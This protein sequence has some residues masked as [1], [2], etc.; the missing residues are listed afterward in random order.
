MLKVVYSVLFSNKH[1]T[2]GFF[3]SNFCC[4][5]FAISLPF[6][7]WEN[8]DQRE[9]ASFCFSHLSG[10]YIPLITLSWQMMQILSLLYLCVSSDALCHCAK[11]HMKSI[12]ARRMAIK[13]QFLESMESKLL[14]CP[15]SLGFVACF[16]K[17]NFLSNNFRLRNYS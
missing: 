7:S 11:L 17:R 9:F 14:C 12:N 10:N 1:L 15:D 3:F 5:S 6:L 2:L 16:H 8:F 4:F 13:P